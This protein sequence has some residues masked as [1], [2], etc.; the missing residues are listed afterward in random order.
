MDDALLVGDLEGLGDL[1]SDAGGVGDGDR[2][3]GDALGEVLTHGDLHDPEA[4]PVHVL[5]AVDTGDVRVREGGENPSLALEALEAVRVLGEG[6][7]KDLE[8]HVASELGVLGPPDLAHPSL[9][10]LRGHLVVRDRLAD[11][12]TFSC[13]SFRGAS[14]SSVRRRI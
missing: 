12:F 11:Q 1:G 2:P 14:S 7:G 5:E 4:L 13:S 9:A 3:P 10:Q 8:G 6:I